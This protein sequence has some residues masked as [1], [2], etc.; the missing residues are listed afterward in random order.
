VND[1]VGAIGGFRGAMTGIGGTL[2]GEWA[3]FEEKDEYML[4]QIRFKEQNQYIVL[5]NVF[6]RQ[7]GCKDY[8]A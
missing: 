5:K 1:G 3:K 4:E 6:I 8:I 2:F 7:T